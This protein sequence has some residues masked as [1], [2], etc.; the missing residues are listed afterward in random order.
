V[1]DIREQLVTRQM[2]DLPA[3]IK[4]ATPDEVESAVWVDCTWALVG[5]Y[6]R[7]GGAY[8]RHCE[9]AVVDLTVPAIVGGKSLSG[10]QPWITNVGSQDQYG[11]DLA[12]EVIAY[13]AGLPRRGAPGSGVPGTVHFPGVGRADWVTAISRLCIQV[14]QSYT[15]VSGHT[16]P[17]AE[18]LLGV[19]SRI[20]ITSMVGEGADC[21]AVL[22]LTLAFTPIAED[23][24]GAPSDCYLQ[25][26]A[27]GE[28][29]LLAA[30][31]ET[32][33]EPLGRSR[34]T[35]GG[36]MRVIN[37]C[38]TLPEEAPFVSAWAPSVARM[39]G[40]WWGSPALVSALKADTFLLRSAATG[41]LVSMGVEGSGALPVLK[42]MLG[43]ADPQTR[44]SAARALGDFGSAAVEALPALTGAINDTDE[45]VQYAVIGAL[46]QIGESQSVP[47]LIQVLHHSNSYTRYVAAEALEKLGPIAAPAIPD[48]IDAIDDEF[49][50]V[51]WTSVDALGAIGPEAEEAIPV[52]I[53]LLEAEDWTFHSDAQHALERITGQDLGEDAAAWRKWYEAK[54]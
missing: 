46:G 2:L 45:S 24:I 31:H 20:G 29:T 11:S 42:E 33:T 48:L 27:T 38:P 39:L 34:S 41:Q 18:D 1:V 25:V 10:S 43:D 37:K 50:Q 23:V 35:G 30:G 3:E 13:I 51:G 44:A 36:G 5:T 52:L 54:P 53:A 7:G 47:A 17:I 15:G 40:Q 8:R 16:E 4:P 9:L 32:L 49:T 12:D 19:L 21:E 22:A 14:E 6:T 26:E 28:A